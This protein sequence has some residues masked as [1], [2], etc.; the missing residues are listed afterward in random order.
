MWANT[1]LPD[2][3]FQSQNIIELSGGEWVGVQQTLD[4]PIVMFRDPATGST[5]ALYQDSLT[6][7]GVKAQMQESR[8]QFGAA[9]AA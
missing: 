3:A 9:V 6:V 2:S 7:A 1:T 4:R 8:A 5:L